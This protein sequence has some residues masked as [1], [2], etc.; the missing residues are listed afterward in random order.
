M[1]DAKRVLEA[2]LLC[3]DQPMVMRDLRTLFDESVDEP[4]LRTLLEEIRGEWTERG[5]QLAE[6]ASG[7]RFQS[8]PDMA[9]YLEKL[10]PE[11]PPRYSRAV[12]ETLVERH[13]RAPVPRAW[14]SQWWV[15]RKRG[16]GADL[17]MRGGFNATEDDSLTEH[18]VQRFG[19]ADFPWGDADRFQVRIEAQ[20]INGQEMLVAF[21]PQ[22]D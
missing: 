10:H 3:A 20:V 19:Y 1:L 12:L 2:A 6:V 18:L 11:K 17:L 5:L 13:P 21:M 4:Q 7:W 8:H 9:H 15:L 16:R 14:M 22:E